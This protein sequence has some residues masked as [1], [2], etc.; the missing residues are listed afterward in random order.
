MNNETIGS[1]TINAS[2]GT[3]I[4]DAVGYYTITPS[5]VTGGTF[6][7]SNYN[8]NYVSGQFQVVYSLYNFQMSGTSSNWVQGTVPIPGIGNIKLTN[9]EYS[10]VTYSSYISP[11]YV[12]ID[13]RGVCYSTNSIPTINDSIVVDGAVTSKELSIDVTN[14]TPQTTYFI[15]TFVKIGN[16]VF[17]SNPY[18]FKTPKKPLNS[19]LL[20]SSTQYLSFPR[21]ANMIASGDFT[22]ETWIKFNTIGAVVMDPIFGG[23]VGDYFSIYSGNIAAR[24][25]VNNPCIADRAF[26]ASSIISTGTWHHMAMVRTGSTITAYLDGAAVGTTSCTGAF[27]NSASVSTILIGKNT[28]RSGNLNAYISNMRLVVGAAVYTSNFTPPSTSLTAIPGTQFLLSVDDVSNPYKD[29]SPNNVTISA[30]GSPVIN[31]GGGPF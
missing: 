19:I 28:W 29:S 23:G 13:Q 1:A 26:A 5:L 10:S 11:A 21:S 3:G 20:A 16:K 24:F 2:G 14:L 17:Y 7:S 4:D 22:F 18:K 31:R 12:N 8:I 30:F 25:D 9:L 27:L 15:R 6:S